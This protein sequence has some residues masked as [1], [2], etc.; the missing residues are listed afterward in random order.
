MQLYIGF[1]TIKQDYFMEYILDGNKFSTLEEFALYFSD[2][3]LKNHQW[4]GSLDAFNDILYG[5]FGT[6][7]NGFVIRWIN[8]D[9]SKNNLG[10]AE[11]IK[12]YKERVLNCHP[13]NTAYM[14]SKLI[15]MKKG[16]G[17]TVFDWIIEIIQKIDEDEE[18]KVELKLEF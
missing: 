2:T 16:I 1:K 11:T 12:W 10:K 8:A 5:G 3:V 7:D 15:E 18:Y 4:R 13:S 14:E 17:S 9:V 6:P